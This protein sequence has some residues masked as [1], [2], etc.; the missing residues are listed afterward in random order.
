MS[1]ADNIRRYREEMDL[2]QA[3]LAE[4]V[5]VDR[6]AVTQWETGVSSP[7]M[8]NVEKLASVFNVRVSDIVSD[9]FRP[10]TEY[11][12]FKMGLL[13]DMKELVDLYGSMTDEGRQQLMI[14]ARG[15]AATYPKNQVDTAAS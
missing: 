5:G 6:T 12:A 13:G 11:Y 2:T 8:G 7:R 9:A 3:Q 10:R 15:L 1:V 14:F 4:K